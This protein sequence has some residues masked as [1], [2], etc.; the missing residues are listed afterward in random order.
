MPWTAP[1]TVDFTDVFDHPDLH[2]H[3]NQLFAGFLADHVFAATADAGRFVFGQFMDDFDTRQLS[4][5]RFAFAS[6][7]D[8][9][10]DF[11]FLFLFHILDGQQW[12]TFRLVEQRQ[13]RGIGL[14]R[15]F[16]FAPEQAVA[17]KLDLFFQIDDVAFMGFQHLS[18]FCL[19]SQCL[20]QQ[21]LEQNRI[22]RKVIGQ[23]N[24]RPDYTGSG[25]ETRRQNLMRT[26]TPEIK[27]VEQPV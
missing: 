26:I 24:H 19:A 13:L 23:G 22:I 12:V 4:R 21:L 11:L 27:S 7:P 1:G 3:D 6:A 25:D 14:D 18:C 20:K 5:Q 9:S 15:L 16:G 10:N 17:Q 8:R 2:W